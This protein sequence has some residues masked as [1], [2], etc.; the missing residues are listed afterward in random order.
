MDGSFFLKHLSLISAH[1]KAL[2]RNRILVEGN[3]ISSVLLEYHY[4]YSAELCRALLVTQL[5]S[6]VI[7]NLHTKPPEVQIAI[8]SNC[9]A[10]IRA[11]YST[12]AT[13]SLSIN[14]HQI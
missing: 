14:L 3:F 10:V 12:I 7:E 13:F 1:F 9:S 5:V 11:L 8:E 6:H 2:I 4:L